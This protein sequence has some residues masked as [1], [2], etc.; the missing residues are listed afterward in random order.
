MSYIPTIRTKMNDI[1]LTNELLIIDIDSHFDKSCETILL[2][3]YS[4]MSHKYQ[5]MMTTMNFHIVKDN[6]P[7]P[8]RYLVMFTS[9]TDKE[10][11]I[12]AL[13]NWKIK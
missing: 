1:Q 7:E 6:R 5:M 11:E 8:H 2:G 9:P 13:C 10:V 12:W 3:R 4:P